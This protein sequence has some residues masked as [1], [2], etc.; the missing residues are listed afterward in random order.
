MYQ[1]VCSAGSRLLVQENIAECLV[2]KIKERM[3]HLRLGDSLDKG[4]DMGPII[5]SSQHKAI[6]SFVEKAR[7]EGADVFQACACLP[8]N[9]CY[10]PPTLITKLQPVSICV[11]E[12]VRHYCSKYYLVLKIQCYFVVYT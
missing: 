10:F 2:T 6:E 5:D 12:E 3:T 9:G 1:Q 8:H 4:I 7:K 11:Q